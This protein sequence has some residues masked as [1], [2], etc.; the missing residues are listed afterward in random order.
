MNKTNLTQDGTDNIFE[1]RK[2]VVRVIELLDKKSKN[3]KKSEEKRK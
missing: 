2:K 3:S 1:V